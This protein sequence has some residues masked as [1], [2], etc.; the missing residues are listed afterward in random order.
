[1]HSW[2][3]RC[4][5]PFKLSPLD[6][7]KLLSVGIPPPPHSRKKN[8]TLWHRFCNSLSPNLV[9]SVPQVLLKCDS[10]M[11]PW[12]IHQHVLGSQD[13]H[14][15]LTCCQVHVGPVPCCRCTTVVMVPTF[16]MWTPFW[17]LA[18]CMRLQLCTNSEVQL[19]KHCCV[20]T[21]SEMELGVLAKCVKQANLGV[22][23]PTAPTCSMYL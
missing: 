14:F 20:A 21:S 18:K 11:T 10:A 23:G 6:Q 3:Q 15:I 16:T 1:M 2:L 4:P 8:Y 5:A 13:W 12:G 22:G 9:A 17:C 7:P 19:G